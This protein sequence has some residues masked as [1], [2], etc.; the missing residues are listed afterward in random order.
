MS[1]KKSYKKIAIIGNP[2]QN[3][4][5]ITLSKQLLEDYE[6][7]KLEEK[8][9]WLEETGHYNYIIEE[10]KKQIKSQENIFEK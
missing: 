2:T 7:K 6:R 1:D 4:N 9:K 5:P 3:T 10:A 8:T